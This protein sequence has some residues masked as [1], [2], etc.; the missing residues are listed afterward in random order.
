MNVFPGTPE[1]SMKR[2]QTHTFSFTVFGLA[3]ALAAAVIWL[4]CTQRAP[5][6]PVESVNDNVT[7]MTHMQATPEQVMVGGEESLVSVQL[8]REDGNPVAGEQITFSTTSGEITAAATTDSDGWAQATLTSG[9]ASGSAVVTAR[10][11]TTV[12]SQITVTFISGDEANLRIE[13]ADDYILA[14]GIDSTRITVTMIGDSAQP[15]VGALIHLSTSHGRIASTAITGDDGTAVA[16][17]RSA[18]STDDMTAT[19]TV[20]YDSLSAQTL[21]HY[22]G[23]T[24]SASADP[25]SILTGGENTSTIAV[26]VKETT[27]NI[28]VSGGSLVFSTDLGTI[29]NSAVTNSSGVAEVNLTSGSTPGVAHV[30]ARYGQTLSDTVEVAFTEESSGTALLKDLTVSETAILANGISQTVISGKVSDSRGN[31]VTGQAVT[32]SASAGTIPGT[33]VTGSNG[34][35]QAT[36]TSAASRTDI[37]AAVIVQMGSQSDTLHVLF[38]GVTSQFTATP[39]TILADGQS[40]S[41]LTYILK[42]TG[43]NE[44]VPDAEIHFGASEGTV[45]A[46][47]TTNAS[48]IG[49]VTLVSGNSAA[50]SQV[51]A[52]Y[53]NALRDTVLVIFT[54]DTPSEYV[55]QTVSA[56]NHSVLANGQDKVT[57]SAVVSD[58]Q[59]NP[60]TGTAVLF[61]ASS[62]TIQSSAVTG[63]DG[64][65]STA[66][67]SVAS[68]NDIDAMVYARL[69]ENSIDSVKVTF[70]GVTMSLTATPA[71]IS[72]DGESDSRISVQLKRTNS[73]VAIPGQTIS[74]GTDVGTI[75]SSGV[76]N[77]SGVANV[78]LVSSTAPGVAHVRAEYGNTILDTVHVTFISDT[79]P[80][81]LLQALTASDPAI[82]A[83][84]VS[85]TTIHTMITD[86]DG[87]AVPGKTVLFTA[88]EGSIIS[89][90]TSGTDGAVS[91]A[92]T[93]SASRMDLDASVVAL[94]DGQTQNATVRFEGIKSAFTAVPST[95]LAD[96]ASTS[97]LT[98]I[99][100]K[101]TSNEAVSGARISFG[102][103][104]GTVP[105][106]GTTNASGIA[107][108]TLVSGTSPAVSDIVATYGN[109]LKDTVQVT[110]SNEAPTQYVLQTVSASSNAI[111]A[112]GEDQVTVLATVTDDKGSPVSGVSVQFTASAGTI[113]SSAVTGG[114]G[115]AQAVF[116]A[117][118]SQTNVNAKAYARLDQS[119]IDSVNVVFEGV[120]M[121]LAAAPDSILADGQSTSLISAVLKKTATNIAIPGETIAFGTDLGTIPSSAVTSISG[122]AGVDLISTNTVGT[123]NVSATYAGMSTQ[124]V[125]VRF[126]V[127]E[128]H[129][130][131][132]TASP[133]VITADGQSQ[134]IIKASV[135]DINHNPV[136][137]GTDVTFSLNGAGTLQGNLKQT[138]SGVATNFLTAGTSPDSAWIRVRVGTLTDS[139]KVQ[140]RVG[141][142]DQVIVE[143]DST[144]LSA[145][146]QSTAVVTARVLDAQ[147]TPIEDAT[148]NFSASIG[149][150]TPTAQTGSN[151]QATASF[152]SGVVGTAT[153]TATVETAGGGSVSG[154]TTIIL[155]PG[156]PNSIVLS[157]NPTAIGVRETGQNQ[158][159][160]IQAEV[161]D[162]KNNPVEDG[163]PVTFSIVHGPGGGESLSSTTPIPTV[164]GKARVSISSGTISGNV[165]VQAQT[166]GASGSIIAKAAEILIHAGPAYMADRDDYSTTSLTILADRYNIWQGMG[167]VPVKI[168]VFDKYHNPVQ[169]NTAVYLTVSGGGI[170]THTAYTDELGRAQVILTAAN[171]QPTITN[172]Y[173]GELMQ[174]PN[175]PNKILP[176]PYQYSDLGGAW[177]LPNFDGEFATGYP[178][179]LGGD[180]ENSINGLFG[181]FERYDGISA[182]SSDYL[183][184]ENDGIAR[185]IAYTE[186]QDANGDSIRVWD[187]ISVIYSGGVS[188]SDDSNSK[189]ALTDL[190]VGD[191]DTYTFRLV[192]SNGNPV[193]SGS[194]IKLSLTNEVD[195]KLDWTSIK[196]PDGFGSGYYSV[197]ISNA[198]DTTKADYKIGNTRITV[199]WENEHQNIVKS[200]RRWWNITDSN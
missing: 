103:T 23:V 45:P 180:I 16:G 59:G 136:P 54:D 87:N 40:T 15:V 148:V 85:Q 130:L 128:P 52:T 107:S 90:A 143:A 170:S 75:P 101:T 61:Y 155:E 89:S 138:V 44:A 129:Y 53:G 165:R 46:T 177:L 162:A 25:T 141:A 178:A 20:G 157:F 188:F 114:D 135:S 124:S 91:A 11:G 146:G 30:V 106:T 184:L 147:G 17:L 9:T 173:Y 176:G 29:P 69:D 134:S 123:A 77:S 142:A 191:A 109:A 96:G 167:E 168:T 47:V 84:G 200:S 115:D 26:Q 189:P 153:I 22:T 179:T 82:L 194:N 50:V 99:L 70:E 80:A 108:V 151:G 149:D 98:Y 110:F 120:T 161:R 113:Q 193:I 93:S 57:I 195:A 166:T 19:V 86:G 186:G 32:F 198:V 74:F 4:A 190:D 88:S 37:P 105:A 34:L 10:H 1:E 14:N 65:A 67:T 182:D 100:K 41:T 126:Q 185:V 58:E 39:S 83:D 78:Q 160:I 112:N 18:A 145:D 38:E 199:E 5:L 137:D 158:T 122:V 139:I 24:V 12:Y 36:L 197:W 154:H 118:A 159:A 71:S 169:K 31:P 33:V 72:A 150:I 63:S 132:L 117:S 68:Q 121:T 79:A 48:G 76:T 64:I 175:Y 127:A 133:P 8:I 156:L 192:D 81:A 49:Q 60:V 104:D 119:S 3:G 73:N 43:S 35:V 62:G 27:S 42:K 172:Y 95:I 196:T 163:T 140:Y 125:Q 28:A 92:L 174:D 111:L 7:L 97:T 21:V 51:V 131:Q 152:S 2:V 55:L 102:A 56:S 94:M 183:N 6:D 116:T 171:P 181:S 144:A 164:D 13:A 187:Q 66:L